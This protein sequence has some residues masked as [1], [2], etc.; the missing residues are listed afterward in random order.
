MRKRG[1][2]AKKGGPKIASLGTPNGATHATPANG[3]NPHDN[4]PGVNFSRV[5]SSYLEGAL[6]LTNAESVKQKLK[7]KNDE[8]RG[9]VRGGDIPVVPCLDSVLSVQSI[10]SD[11]ERG[12]EDTKELKHFE[13][14]EIVLRGGVKEEE[15]EELGSGEAEGQKFSCVVKNAAPL[16]EKRFVCDE[17]LS[18]RGREASD[19]IGEGEAGDNIGEGETGDNIGEAEQG[20]VSHLFN[21]TKEAYKSLNLE[22]LFLSNSFNNPLRG[23]GGGCER[24]CGGKEDKLS[25]VKTIERKLKGQN[26]FVMENIYNAF[27][28]TINDFIDVY[29]QG[30]DEEVGE[31]RSKRAVMRKDTT[32]RSV[33]PF[34]QGE[35]VNL[36]DEHGL[37]KMYQMDSDVF[38][39]GGEKDK[40]EVKQSGYATKREE[41]TNVRDYLSQFGGSSNSGGNRNS[42]G[43]RTSGGKTTS[44]GNPTPRDSKNSKCCKIKQGGANP[45]GEGN[46]VAG[47]VAYLMG[48]TSRL[49]RGGPSKQESHPLHRDIDKHKQVEEA[50]S[51][52]YPEGE[53]FEYSSIISDYLYNGKGWPERKK[54]DGG[55]P[56]SGH[57]AEKGKR[58][59][60][61]CELHPSMGSQMNTVLDTQVNDRSVFDISP[62]THKYKYASNILLTINKIKNVERVV[63]INLNITDVQLNVPGMRVENVIL[64]HKY[65]S[66][67][68]TIKIKT[69][70]GGYGGTYREA[71]RRGETIDAHQPGECKTNRGETNEENVT[72]KSYF[73]FIPLNNIK[74]GIINKRLTLISSKRKDEFEKE[75]LL[76]DTLYTIE[77]QELNCENEKHMYISLK[78]CK[79]GIHFF[80]SVD[81]H[82]GDN[83]N[84]NN[85]TS[86]SLTRSAFEPVYVCLYNDEVDKEIGSIV[87]GRGLA[88][89]VRINKLAAKGHYLVN[90]LPFQF[91]FNH[92]NVLLCTHGDITEEADSLLNHIGK[93]FIR[94]ESLLDLFPTRIFP[95]LQDVLHMDSIERNEF[96]QLKFVLHFLAIT[97][98]ICLHLCSLFGFH[99]DVQPLFRDHLTAVKMDDGTGQGN[100]FTFLY[101]SYEEDAEPS[102]Y[103]LNY[104]KPFVFRF[105]GGSNWG[106]AE[107]KTHPQWDYCSDNAEGRPPTECDENDLFIVDYARKQAIFLHNAIKHHGDIRGIPKCY[108]R[109]RRL[110]FTADMR[111]K[112]FQIYYMGVLRRYKL[113]LSRGESAQ[114][115]KFSQ[116]AIQPGGSEPNSQWG[117]QTEFTWNG[118]NSTDGGL[119]GGLGGGLDGRL[120]GCLDGGSLRGDIPLGVP[121]PRDHSPFVKSEPPKRQAASTSN[122]PVC[123]DGMEDEQVGGHFGGTNWEERVRGENLHRGRVALR[124]KPPKVENAYR[125]NVTVTG[126]A[127][128]AEE[129]SFAGGN[130]TIGEEKKLSMRGETTPHGELPNEKTSF[131]NLREYKNYHFHGDQAGQVTC[132]NGNSLEN[133]DRGRDSHEEINTNGWHVNTKGKES[134]VGEL[135]RLPDGEIDYYNM[136]RED[137]PFSLESVQWDFN[138][139]DFYPGE[140]PLHAGCSNGYGSR[141]GDGQTVSIAG[142]SKRLG[143]R[144][145]DLLALGGNAR[146]P[147]AADQDWAPSKLSASKVCNDHTDHAAK[148]CKL[149]RRSDNDG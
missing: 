97:E 66:D 106:S 49:A 20:N 81:P 115:G 138:D 121:H 103:F 68:L 111:K 142:G 148:H 51:A 71:M 22:K 102:G 76:P 23:E 101:T 144:C 50:Y 136:H 84:G 90:N 96:L 132:K 36:R 37:K 123:T 147:G 54:N 47:A 118:N 1:K 55:T 145:A 110:F 14:F 39:S 107:G 61:T 98:I 63:E 28:G 86:E 58:D 18:E 77:S 79:N 143:E 113:L 112:Q 15:E 60:K 40:I 91:H 108:D 105:Q 19:N 62:M 122:A 134:T 48:D 38:L 133:L 70:S 126:Q 24:E 135:P 65:A 129:R 131:Y 87:N 88:N 78:I 17:V 130:K 72:I 127:K 34:R 137:V 26:S 21:K 9:M 42:W 7:R 12:G 30:E 43:D 6:K 41:D 25:L 119:G 53:S 3:A 4:I 95:P 141:G 67:L 44:W 56:S 69:L 2:N 116:V 94:V 11:H 31:G 80:P 104:T 109:K 149:V 5:K 73:V 10:P 125:R 46:V 128:M 146:L 16:N 100:R 89:K 13:E 75:G 29:L 120:D 114:L 93:E 32:I 117:S 85:S 82:R 64:P 33:D 45:F 124:G 27:R 52:Y 59:G 99:V 57:N 92:S 74:E 139:D 83:L 35:R 8:L 140:D